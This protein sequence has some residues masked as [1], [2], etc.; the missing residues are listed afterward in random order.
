M[1]ETT[2]KRASRSSGG[3]TV[4]RVWTTAGVH[5]YDQVTW[6]SRVVWSVTRRGS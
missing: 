1:T 5:P 6:E 3:L 2:S 4:E